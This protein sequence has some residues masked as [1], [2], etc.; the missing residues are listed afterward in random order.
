MFPSVAAYAVAT[1]ATCA[2]ATA[3]TASAA[4]FTAIGVLSSAAG[5]C[6][7]GVGYYIHPDLV[8][9]CRCVVGGG[10]CLV[11]NMKR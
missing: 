4:S 8:G 5:L 2:A 3:A 10:C 9:I 7:C 6:L 1:V 11:T